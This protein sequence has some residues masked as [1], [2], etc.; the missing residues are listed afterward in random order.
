MV[1]TKEIIKGGVIF[2]IATFLNVILYY[3]IPPIME[4]MNGLFSNESLTQV[5]WYGTIILMITMMTIV[6]SYFIIKGLTTKTEQNKLTT[7]MTGI[8]FLLFGIAI[9][10]KGWYMI[11][12]ITGMINSPLIL[13]LFWIGL[14]TIFIEIIIITPIYCAFEAFKGE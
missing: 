1:D 9:I 8:I 3:T 4:T 11:S 5:V 13:V 7:I 10:I 2:F 14:I 6:P 12:T